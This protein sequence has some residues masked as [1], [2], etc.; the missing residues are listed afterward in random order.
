ML[1][2]LT[3]AY[4][5]NDSYA[6]QTG[7]TVLF[8]AAAGGVGLLA[9]QSLASKGVTAIGTAGGAEKCALATRNG[10]AHIIDYT[11]E[12]FVARVQDITG[13]KGVKAVYDSVGKDTVKGSLACLA[14][15]GSLIAFG[16]SSG[17]YD[18]FKIGDLAAGSFYVQ[19]PILFHYTADRVWLENAAKSLFDGIASETLKLSI[20]EHPLSDVAQVHNDLEARRTT[21]STV[22]VP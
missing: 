12:D 18:A 14:N 10:Y 9:G 7:D 21:G 11:S 2:G 19:R 17:P 15:F 6:V 3:C 20:T 22:L 4:L 8:H 5:L 13:G 16:Q 1:K